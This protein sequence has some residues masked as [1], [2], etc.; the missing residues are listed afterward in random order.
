M[1]EMNILL[2]IP[3]VIMYNRNGIRIGRH[4]AAFVYS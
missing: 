3:L 1:G 4:V 2:A